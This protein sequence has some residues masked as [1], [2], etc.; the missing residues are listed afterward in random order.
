MSVI[1]TVAETGG[2]SVAHRLRFLRGGTLAAYTLD[3]LDRLAGDLARRLLADGLRPGDRIGIL[4][5]NGI[6][7]VL[8]DLAAIKAGL[9]T[10]GFEFGKFDDPPALAARY[11]LA[12]LLSDVAFEPGSTKARDLRPAVSATLEAGPDAPRPPETPAHAWALDDG[13]TLKFTSGSTGEP[14]GLAATVGSIESSIAAVQSIFHHGDGDTILV[15]LPLSLLQQRY[16][17]YSAL[18][19]GHDVA[20]APFEY[21]LP[22]AA[23][24]R[25]TVIMGVPGFFES[26]KKHI[27]RGGLDPDDLAGRKAAIEALIGPDIRYLWTGS[28]PASRDM[29][30]FFDDCGVPIF[31][32]Y[33][34]NETCIV[35]KNHPGAN[36]IGS[37]GRLLPGKHAR[38]DDDGVLIVGA[39]HPVNTAYA[40]CA[41]GESEKVFLPTGEVRTGDLARFDEDGFLWILGRAD[42]VVVLAN[43]KNVHVRGI[44]ERIRAHAAIDQCVLFGSGQTYLVAVV[45]P[46]EPL[47]AWNCVQE[48]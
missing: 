17:I 34:M 13:T 31:E 3:E 45:S 19:H 25:P 33:G 10:A 6:E 24:V 40:Y 14:K 35:T 46:T 8:L 12:G 29:L 37:A 21:A 9:I 30:E 32:G 20:V 22:V 43:G 42:D 36:R 23:Q 4:A 18:A 39:D 26:L 47:A 28:A 1:D 16:W 38:I 2:K 48:K 27:E 15:F 11:G 7:W 44:E 41:P 5:R